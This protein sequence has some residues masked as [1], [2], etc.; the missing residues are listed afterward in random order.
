MAFYEQHSPFL[1]PL[2]AGQ[3]RFDCLLCKNYSFAAHW[4]NEMEIILVVEG[5]YELFADG[6]GKV[7]DPG[8]IFICNS[9][10]IHYGHGVGARDQEIICVFNRCYLDTAFA[11]AY[12]PESFLDQEWAK[13][14]DVPSAIMQQM[15]HCLWKICEEQISFN[16]ERT[17]LALKYMNL[18][19]QYL[20][21]YAKAKDSGIAI[22]SADYAIM[23]QIILYID[24]NYMLPLE[25]KEISEKFNISP[26]R[27]TREFQ[28]LT[29]KSFKEYLSYVRVAK[30]KAALASSSA[31]IIS[32]AMNAG[33]ESVRTF[34]RIFKREEGI[35]PREYRRRMGRAS[36]GSE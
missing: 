19:M 5:Q 8:D 14:T 11:N 36:N 13:K 29:G 23:Q 17:D 34:N 9:G 30:V 31:S 16:N 24:G 18:L 32:I 21:Y 7:L 12:F 3:A 22:K 15:R 4:H 2:R 33:F 35:N 20:V 28:K 6:V 27:L 10:Q 26:K 1:N 25:A